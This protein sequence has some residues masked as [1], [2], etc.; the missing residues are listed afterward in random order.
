MVAAYKLLAFGGA[1]TVAAFSALNSYEETDQDVPLIVW[2]AMLLA[3]IGWVIVGWALWTHGTPGGAP[4]AGW[5]RLLAPLL[6]AVMAVSL[7]IH[8]A[9]GRDGS[10]VEGVWDVVAFG[11]LALAVAMAGGTAKAALLA[12]SGA[13]LLA[14]SKNVLMPIESRARTV[15]GPGMALLPV[16][17]VM[18]ALAL[19]ANGGAPPAPAPVGVPRVPV[20]VP[21]VVP[22]MASLPVA[23]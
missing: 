19:V 5:A 7:F 20:A 1:I 4:S 23:A 6:V 9:V 8:R 10:T 13:G 21:A 16:A 2:P 22:T 15:Y 3:I 12:V 14:L 18:L 17:W 11:V